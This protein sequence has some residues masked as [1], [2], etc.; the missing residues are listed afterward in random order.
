METSELLTQSS[1]GLSAGPGPAMVPRG[2]VCA[3]A[4]A[5]G[6]VLTAGGVTA[7]AGTET[8]AAEVEFM[9]TTPDGEATALGMPPLPVPRSLHTCTP[10]QDGSAL[11]TGGLETTQLPGTVLGDAYV[12]IAAP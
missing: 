2:R 5:Q 1:T 9:T 3:V 11:I 4:L 7:G 6:A 12:F 8:S 10:L